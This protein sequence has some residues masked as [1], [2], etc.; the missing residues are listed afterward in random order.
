MALPN[1]WIVCDTDT[2]TKKTYFTIN[3]QIAATATPRQVQDFKFAY[4][5]ASELERVLESSEVPDSTELAFQTS[6]AIQQSEHV[7]KV[8]DTGVLQDYFYKSNHRI[9]LIVPDRRSK[10]VFGRDDIPY[11]FQDE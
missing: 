2:E 5:S 11:L 8:C 10:R 6:Y 4:P 1:L 3:H 9:E 7:H